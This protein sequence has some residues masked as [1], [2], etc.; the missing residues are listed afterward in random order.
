M[1][2]LGFYSMQ[3]MACVSLNRIRLHYY[4]SKGM[5]RAI[6]L[7][8]LLHNPS[9]LFGTTLIA[10]N[11]A[12][13]TGSEFS[14]E[15][16]VSLG[17]NPDL[18]PLTQV[19]LVV[20]FAELAPMF[21]ARRY[22]E[23]VALMGAPILYVSAKIITPLLWALGVISKLCNF[24]LG[25]KEEPT[26]AI[27]NQSA[28]QQ[29]LDDQDEDRGISEGDGE[30]FNA[31][32]ANIF[33]LRTKEAQQVMLP[34]QA[35]TCLPSN[36]PVSQIPK[37][38][39]KPDINYI[40]LFHRDIHHIIGIVTARN[41]TRA[42]D[43]RRVGDFAQAPWFITKTT[44]AMQILKEFRSNNQ[45][46]AIV[47]DEQGYAVGIITLKDLVQEIFGKEQEEKKSQLTKKPVIIERS[48]PADFKVGEFNSQFDVILDEEL[49]ITLAQLM[50]KVLG[51]RPELD[52]KAYIPPFELK[53][54]EMSLLEI[55]GISVTTRLG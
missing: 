13:I 8:W 45:N 16:Y 54:S 12:M 24:L 30:Y 42:P 41:L 10:V 1:I 48:F 38:F 26:E 20:V 46:V 35:I 47:L 36:T 3:E 4:V 33:T 17:L 27:L 5:K 55:K 52:E 49:D 14:R 7:N 23:Q 53:V 15:L 18:A 9:R 34:I 19:I 29:I 32:S 50:E 25:G 44:R 2:V 21:A 40:L 22:A 43:A 37:F 6:W 51:H 39:R 28:L 31:I 11:C